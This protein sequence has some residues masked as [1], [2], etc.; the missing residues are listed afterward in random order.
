MKKTAFIGLL[1]SVSVSF[2]FAQKTFTHYVNKSGLR[3]KL[4]D[5]ADFIRVITG[6]DSS[7][8]YAVSEYYRTGELYR[9]GVVSRYEPVTFEG[10]VKT[11]FKN[12]QL[13]SALEYQKGVPLGLGKFFYQSGALKK[14][15]VF[16][17]LTDEHSRK[18]VSVAKVVSFL[19][20]LGKVMV[21]NGK[22]HA[23]DYDEDF[24]AVEEGDFEDGYKAGVWK[25]KSLK[26]NA[27][28]EENY[29]QG[30]LVSGSSTDES[31][32]VYPYTKLSQQPQ[33]PGGL[34]NF[35]RWVARNFN[36]PA[37]ARENGVSGKVILD[38]FIEKDGSIKD[39]ELLQDPGLGTGKAALALM[40]KCPK[41]EPGRGRG[42]PLR[43][44]FSLPIMLNVQSRTESSSFIAPRKF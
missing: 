21:V 15:Q 36:Y 7:R 38:F 30:K 41:W 22:G 28:Y 23:V 3:V 25:G 5:S 42:V 17:T 8:N 12:G 43:V 2:V 14:L 16:Q 39:V 44:K 27:S 19:D 18:K 32:Q 4:K 35:Y 37:A 33:F 40:K 34:E 10:P 20:S 29:L 31:G 1:L 6:P 13:S 9:T 24:D 11:F 26:T